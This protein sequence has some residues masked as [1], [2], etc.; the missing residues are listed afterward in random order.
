MKIS[1]KEIDNGSKN[2]VSVNNMLIGDVEV[3]L[4]NQKWKLNPYF[5]FYPRSQSILYVE[6]ESFYK[7]GKALA[8]LYNDTFISFDEESD[9]D[10]QEIDMRDVLKLY[11]P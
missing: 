10:T 7:A 6:Y 11:S 2:Q 1:F 3:N 9:I 5:T 8:K 4:W